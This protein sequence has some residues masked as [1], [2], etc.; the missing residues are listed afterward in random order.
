MPRWI[1][2]W[3]D[4]CAR[5]CLRVHTPREGPSEHGLEEPFEASF[6]PELL[7][8]TDYTQAALFAMEVALFRLIES[9][10]M[11]PDYLM[12]HSIGELAAAHV[13]G[14]FS[15]EDACTL[16]AARGRLMERARAGRS[17]GV[18]ADVRDGGEEVS[19]GLCETV[20]AWRR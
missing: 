18:P 7:D 8:R 6:D 2:T 1:G 10:G 15:L 20:F 14:V 19:R 16:V 13:S 12:G 17:D 3:S 11:H 4:P 5:C 9:L